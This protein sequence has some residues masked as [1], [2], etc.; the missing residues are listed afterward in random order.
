MKQNYAFLL[1]T[2]IIVSFAILG[3]AHAQA[4][5]G[6]PPT[7]TLVPS[8]ATIDAGQSVAFTNITTSGTPGYAYSYT[9]NAPDAVIT[10]NSILFPTEGTYGVVE[11]VEDSTGANVPSEQAVITVNPAPTIIITPSANSINIG[12][13]VT[14][15]ANI[16]GGTGPFT[17]NLLY[18]CSTVETNTIL[19]P[20]GS[21]SLAFT[22]TTTGTDGMAAVLSFN[23]VATD[24]GAIE[25]GTFTFGSNTVTLTVNPVLSLNANGA[26]NVLVDV[27]GGYKTLL[28]YTPA[29]V[30]LI[31]RSESSSSF[32]A[33]ILITNQSNN[34]AYGSPTPTNNATVLTKLAVLSVSSDLTANGISYFLLV[35]YTC[36]TTVAPYSYNSATGGW[37]PVNTIDNF[38]NKPCGIIFQ[39]PMNPVIG[40]FAETPAPAPTTTS[41]TTISSGGSGNTGGGTGGGAGGGT[42][43]GVG[44]G[45]TSLPTVLAYSS[46]TRKGYQI[47][48]ITN[49][50]SETL[51]LSNN[52]KTIDITINFIT[53]TSAGITANNKAYNLTVDSPV[54][55]VDPNNYTYYAELTAI[56]YLPILHTI[57]LLVYSQ[58]N[59]PVTTTTSTTTAPPT[60]TI[61]RP[62]TTLP[63]TTTAAPTP[64]TSSIPTPPPSRGAASA[65]LIGI[66]IVVIAVVLVL[67]IYY[68]TNIRKRRRSKSI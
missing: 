11:Y 26:A 15:T 29:G 40:I 44:G 49:H 41:T 50:N 61:T 21:T 28:N 1:F 35:D 7:I 65:L 17:V 16:T 19:L 45:G 12:Q 3:L 38:T 55:L 46:G 5:I 67:L 37:T 31:I 53:P 36:G 6:P 54:A 64:P 57:T 13:S 25:A 10:G 33:N 32:F 23:A 34:A 66:I 60:T 59:T 22:P 48:N 68:S 24:T 47:T 9:T 14:Y 63:A 4:A 43:G 2:A 58:P 56:S 51:H 62:T 52:T 18:N 42:G 30:Q 20:G 27:P 39:M 8:T